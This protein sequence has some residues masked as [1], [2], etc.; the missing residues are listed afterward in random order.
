MLMTIN[1]D[2]LI[3]SFELMALGMA[4]VFVVLGILYIVAEA[5]IKLFP[6][7]K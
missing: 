5:L 1:I 4:G 6:V 3:Q 7:E 2:H